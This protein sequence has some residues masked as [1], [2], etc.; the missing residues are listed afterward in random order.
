MGVVRE[1]GSGTVERTLWWEGLGLLSFLDSWSTC[2]RLA[3]S[4]GP[5]SALYEPQVCPLGWGGTCLQF[6]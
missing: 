5:V 6:H 4:E 3:L 2:S 1:E